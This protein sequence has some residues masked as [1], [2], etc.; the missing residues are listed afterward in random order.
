MK[1]VCVKV[2]E[3]LDDW[4]GWWLE[5]LMFD[6]CLMYWFEVCLGMFGVLWWRVGSNEW[7]DGCCWCDDDEQRVC[8]MRISECCVGYV[9]WWVVV[10]CKWEWCVGDGCLMTCMCLNELFVVLTMLFWFV[11]GLMIG[12]S[13]DG[14]DVMIDCCVGWL[15]CVWCMMN[16]WMIVVGW[17]MIVERLYEVCM[18]DLWFL[19]MLM[20]IF[21]GF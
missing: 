16:G 1:M 10:W 15:G 2:D 14:V 3:L 4:N 9:V 19:M 6:V 8:L 18:I 13:G 11:R 21:W 20:W 12:M 7:F 17:L 5:C